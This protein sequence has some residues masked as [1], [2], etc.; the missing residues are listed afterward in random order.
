[1]PQTLS[2]INARVIDMTANSERNGRYVSFDLTYRGLPSGKKSKKDAEKAGDYLFWS[3]KKCLRGHL[4]FRYTSNSN[5]RQCQIDRS[6]QVKLSSDPEKQNN[7]RVADKRK[8]AEILMEKIQ[9]KKEL[10]DFDF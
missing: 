2:G 10:N 7:D 4:G 1:M 8:K 6:R 9:L 5:C 3:E